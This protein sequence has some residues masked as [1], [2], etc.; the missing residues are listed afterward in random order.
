MIYLCNTYDCDIPLVTIQYHIYS[1][2]YFYLSSTSNVWRNH[3]LHVVGNA[4]V[5][6]VDTKFVFKGVFI[7][8]AFFQF[9]SDC[10]P[11]SVP[12]SRA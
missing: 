11:P 7:K 3:G 12:I 6:Y 5:L 8:R 10:L 2:L 9:F 1:F 4:I